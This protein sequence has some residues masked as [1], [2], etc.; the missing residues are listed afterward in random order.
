M[1]SLLYEHAEKKGKKTNT[2]SCPFGQEKLCI[3]KLAL[4]STGDCDKAVSKGY[5]V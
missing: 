2:N 5:P 4:K 3:F 1:V